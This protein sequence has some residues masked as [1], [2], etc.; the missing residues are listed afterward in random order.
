MTRVGSSLGEASVYR[1]KKKVSDTFPRRMVDLCRRGNVLV[2]YEKYATRNAFSRVLS[3]I[4]AAQ[5]RNKTQN[6]RAFWHGLLMAQA[7]NRF[8]V[9]FASLI[10]NLTRKKRHQVEASHAC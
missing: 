2:T 7:P 9:E 8:V 1:S 3:L 4:R 10:A 5:N 6:L